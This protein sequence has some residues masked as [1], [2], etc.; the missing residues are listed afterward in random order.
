MVLGSAAA[1]FFGSPLIK[2]GLSES[3]KHDASGKKEKPAAPVKKLDVKVDVSTPV[4]R[5]VIDTLDFAARMTAVNYVEVRAHV[6]GYLD[7]VNFKEGSI[8]KKGDVLF[9]LDARTYENQFKQAKAMVAQAEAR[10]RFDEE[11]LSRMQRTVSS[12]SKS[13]LDKAISTRDLDQANLEQ[14]KE[15]VKQYQLSLEYSKITSPISGRISRYNVTTGN[16][17]QSGDQSGGTLLT[18]IVSVDP[19]HAYFDVDEG[20]VLRNLNLVRDGKAKPFR[21][22]GTKVKLRLDDNGTFTR[23]GTTDFVDNQINPKTGTLRMRASFDNK[24]EALAPGMF[25]TITLPMGNKHKALMVRESALDSDQGQRVLCVLTDKNIV[26]RRRVVVGEKHEGLVE[27]VSGLRPGEKVIVKGVQLAQ[28]GLQVDDDMQHS[29]AMSEDAPAQDK[30]GQ[31]A[32][33]AD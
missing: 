23:E 28:G 21:E 14:A 18:T 11:E 9:E 20:A 24:D 25:A 3:A 7:K 1:I 17:V 31:K 12:I 8:V 19:I 27:I 5:D 10:L 30:T 15:S 2:T 4:E 13:E 32:A 6:W 26:D 33:K 22:L 29:V 16:L